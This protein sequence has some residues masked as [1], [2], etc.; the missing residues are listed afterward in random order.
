MHHPVV[1]V[2]WLA[3]MAFLVAVMATKKSHK[4]GMKTAM[5]AVFAFFGVWSVYGMVSS[6]GPI[7]TEY[8]SLFF[9]IRV[10]DL[11]LLAVEHVI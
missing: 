9:G 11:H 3:M 5:A 10:E 4:V 8:I 6:G 7:P 1:A 2:F